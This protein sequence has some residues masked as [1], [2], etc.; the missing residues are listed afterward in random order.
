MNGYPRDMFE[1]M[2]TIFYHLFSRMHEDFMDGSPQVTG[3]RIVIDSA[4]APGAMQESPA[5]QPRASL[6]PAAEV[7]RLD[8]EVKVIAEL[9]GA[10]RES[11]RLDVQGSMLIIDADGPDT[12]YHTA[13]SLPAVDSGSIQSTFRNGVLEVTFRV[14]PEEPVSA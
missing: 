10:A 11:I 13:A 8:D 7:H 12:P 4:M 6:N 3:F 9:P 5:H 2:D 14:L 1:E